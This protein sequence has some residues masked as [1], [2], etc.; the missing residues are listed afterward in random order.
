MLESIRK[1]RPYIWGTKFVFR[2][3]YDTLKW[4]SSM[5]LEASKYARW[6]LELQDYDFIVE[7]IPGSSN[8]TADFLSRNFKVADCLTL[9]CSF[10]LSAD[11]FIADAINPEVLKEEQSK[12]PECQE[13]MVALRD[14][15]NYDTL[16]DDLQDTIS[17]KMES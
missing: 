8:V 10:F 2:T 11:L 13:I 9:D 1:F 16:N 7:H 5:S 6:I 17:L 12:D 3:D 14:Y 15:P 4:M